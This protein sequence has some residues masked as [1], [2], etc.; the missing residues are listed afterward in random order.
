MENRLT[1]APEMPELVFDE[2]P[3]IYRLNGI[4]IPSVSNVMEPLSRAKY[5]HISAKTLEIAANRG[6]EVHNSIE[7]FLK[8]G[9]SDIDPEFAGY[10]NAFEAWYKG[11]EPDVVG[12]EVRIY[13]KLMQYAGTL[14]LLCYVKD[15]LC[16]YDFKTTSVISDMTCGVQL[17]A[18][19]QALTTH[20]INVQR[21]RIL[22]LKKDGKFKERE[23]PTSDAP[24]WRVFGALKT[25]YDYVKVA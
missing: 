17:E 25:V 3:H 14:D 1:A 6:T 19:A 15:E 7:N 18:Y 12:S 16:I 23:Y 8:F 22:H 20:G 9:F 5:D 10:I 4:K 24:R 11:T 2:V 21:K 13:H